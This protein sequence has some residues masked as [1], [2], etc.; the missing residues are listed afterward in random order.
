MLKQVVGIKKFFKITY[1]QLINMNEYF[2]DE[3]HIP[4]K[5]EKKKK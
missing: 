5:K 4:L 1:Q 3:S 2:F